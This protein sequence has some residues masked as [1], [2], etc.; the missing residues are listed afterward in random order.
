MSAIEPK[1][2]VYLLLN[3]AKTR[4]Y[5][6]ATI[7]PDRRL[8]QHNGELVGGARATAGDSWTRV[9]LVRG[10]PD[11]RAA[12]QFEWMWKHL[13]RKLRSAAV[14]ERRYKAL[15][16]LVELGKSS[17]TSMSFSS[18][19]SPLVIEKQGE[20]PSTAIQPSNNIQSNPSIDFFLRL[21]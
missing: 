7:D 6:G 4:T 20:Q 3:S 5:V 1:W 17:R 19:S 21:H 2:H 18:W 13:T 10:F 16:M 8:R 14:L 15:K 12:L 11:E 9:C